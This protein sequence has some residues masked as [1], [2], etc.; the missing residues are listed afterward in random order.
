M[1]TTRPVE[2]N[3][4]RNFTPLQLSSVNKPDRRRSHYKPEHFFTHCKHNN[5][6]AQGLHQ[7]QR[8]RLEQDRE[9][10][11]AKECD[12]CSRCMCKGEAC[13]GCPVCEDRVYHSYTFAGKQA[14]I[15]GI[16]MKKTESK[17]NR[18]VVDLTKEEDERVELSNLYN[19]MLNRRN[20]AK[21]KAD[22]IAEIEKLRI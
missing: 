15:E 6:V 1:H 4:D 20:A 21:I 16:R 3:G 22:F 5:I 19:E 7:C 14:K 8:C 18:H 9:D 17:F 2:N 10:C 13:E 12:G 11:I